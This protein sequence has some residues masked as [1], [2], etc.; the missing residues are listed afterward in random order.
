MYRYIPYMDPMGHTVD[1][2]EIRRSPVDMEEPTIIY[3]GFIHLSAGFLPSTV[4]MGNTPL[5]V[6]VHPGFFNSSPLKIGRNPK[7]KDR[8]PTIIF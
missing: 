5:E 7:G 8:F 4:A 2:S 3:S 6:D 1:G